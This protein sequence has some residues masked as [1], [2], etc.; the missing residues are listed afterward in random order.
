MTV[1]KY[2][3]SI[4]AGV[5]GKIIGVYLGRPVEG[6]S[7]EK[8]RET[9]GEIRYFV[10]EELGL[11]LV[12]ADDDISGTFGFFKAI[13]DN[14]Y[15]RGISAKDFG[16]AWLNYIIEDKTVLWWGGL[17]R[18]TE[19]TAY[20]RL[21]SGIGAPDSGSIRLNGKTLAEQI[22]AQIFMDALAM[23][24]PGDP[25]QA[26][27]LIR[28]AASVSH[29]GL[30]VEAACF[31]G[32]MESLAFDIRPLDRIMDEALK[33]VTSDFLKRVIDDVRTVCARESE[34]RAV[35][36][37]LDRHY[38]PDRY[39]G[40]CH[41]VPNH[42]MVLASLLLGGDD[43]QKS[44][45]IAA[46]A[47]W[48]TDCN[49][50]NVGCLN[51]IRLGL[52]G[53]GA[54]ADFRKPVADRM[55]VVTADGG[56]VVTD[57]VQQTRQIL[58][59]AAAFKGEDL[60]WTDKRY[61]F[62]FRGSTQGFTVCPHHRTVYP[63]IALGNLNEL[64]EENGLVIECKGLA[65]GVGAFV[66]T[67]V[68]LDFSSLAENF[69]TFASPT[70]YSTQTVVAHV[71]AYAEE[72]PR[73][74]I[75]VLYYDADNR[76]QKLESDVFHLRQG[77]NE[78]S[79]KVPDT[80]GMPIFRLGLE[81]A[82]NRR[83]DGRIAILDLDWKG[84]PESF[85]LQG[86]LMSSI[87][88][89]HPYWLRAW[90]SSA[91]NFAPDFKYTLCISH[92]E[93]NGVVT[94]GTQDWKD[95]AVSSRVSF[96]LHRAGGLVLRSKGHRRYYAAVLSG[97]NTASIL[98]RRNEEIKVLASTKF[99]YEEDAQ[100]HLLFEAKGDEL[101]LSVD[102]RRLLSARDRHYANGAAGFIVE[103]GTML[104]DGFAV[105]RV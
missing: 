20:L 67:P 38:G 51:G 18:S 95:Y 61:G 49:A 82:A 91:K 29:D 34:W 28:K 10:H 14:D 2:A 98:M 89:L 75:Y 5:L 3:E 88:N 12:V 60:E 93:D 27:S 102:G 64:S 72:N 96:S 21:K 25:E 65:R 104:A 42:A 57:A 71:K 22:G 53:I 90:M 68:F 32:A 83:F 66:S 8:I 6:W 16:D 78:I 33:Y 36:D 26:V 76:V 56:S 54:G 44:V 50:G 41:I 55:Y 35:R 52:Q 87:W 77:I 74:R 92:P 1:R 97:G 48:D 45:T 79:W 94:I 84:A 69:S 86:M 70:L 103:R 63:A 31:L 4:Y 100:Y 47:G 17:G 46:S 101:T 80:G 7:Y 39:P 40:P 58:R 81:L 23:M 9:F 15:T 19:H 59:A 24:S 37:W 43:F 13:E 99:K 73:I 30:A 85:V 11:P 105:K 62:E